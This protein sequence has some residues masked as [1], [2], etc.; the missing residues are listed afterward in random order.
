MCGE[1]KKASNKDESQNRMVCFEES[2]EV[3]LHC[4]EAELE[5]SIRVVRA[6]VVGVYVSWIDREWKNCVE[7]Q[8]LHP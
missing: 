2:E 7:R 6:V 3:R 8:R 4:D 1:R 5:D